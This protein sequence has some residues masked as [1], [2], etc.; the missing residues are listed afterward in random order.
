M[1]SAAL[2]NCIGVWAVP[3]QLQGSSRVFR[4]LTNQRNQLSQLCRMTLFDEEVRFTTSI[5]YLIPMKEACQN[6]LKTYCKN[7]PH[8]EGMAIRCAVGGSGVL[9]K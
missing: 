8:E 6:E 4:C 1:C 2:S 9:G 3:L 5:D 7:V